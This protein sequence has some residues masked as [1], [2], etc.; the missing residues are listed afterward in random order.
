[1]RRPSNSAKIIST[2][3]TKVLVV[4]LFIGGIT[5]ALKPSIKWV[6]GQLLHMDKTIHQGSL[7]EQNRS[8]WC[9]HVLESE[10]I[11]ESDYTDCEVIWKY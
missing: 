5:L 3:G 10:S 4:V 11:S 7:K 2:S 9:A 1:M 6:K 8:N